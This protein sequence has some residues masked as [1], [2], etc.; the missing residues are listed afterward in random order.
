MPKLILENINKI[1]SNDFHAV[2]D[3]N[4][5][6]SDG[7]FMV[8]VGPS[9]CGKSTVLRMIAGLEDIS[10]G[11]LIYDG[12]IWNDLEPKKRNIGMVF[13]NYALYPH[14]TVAENLAFPLSVAKVSKKEIMQKVN[15]TANIIGLNELLDRKPKQLS[16]GQRQRV[17]LGR[18]IIRKP[19]LFL[20]DEPLSNLDAKLRVQMRNEIQ[21]LH[22]DFG[23]SSIYVTHDQVEAMTM[24][25]RL[26]VMNGGEIMQV[27]TPEKIYSD[28]D[29]LF[30]AG[31]IGSP[32]MNFFKGNIEAGI[33][34]ESESAVKFPINSIDLKN[35][36]IGIRPE[37]FSL[38]NSDSK[39]DKINVQ[40]LSSEFLGHET[41]IYFK[42]AETLKRVRI[43]EN[44]QDDN[45]KNLDLYYN[46]KDLL[47][48]DSDG[49]RI[50]NNNN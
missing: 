3:V 34:Y 30:V 1:Y 25:T 41:I 8:L 19:N 49:I 24:G 18:A 44:L 26:A 14:L 22:K 21:K 43:F 9:G 13:Q 12:K 16:G 45:I 2:K 11:N 46:R 42:T 5:T 15:E 6:V 20:F 32:E 50:R 10:S 17:A 33:F 29:N 23:V 48:F 39:T 40:I 27:D 36:T 35:V 47:L 4:L 7:E 28:P 38:T 31:F 37:A